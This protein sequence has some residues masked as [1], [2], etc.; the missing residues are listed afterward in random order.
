MDRTINKATVQ[1]FHYDSHDRLRSHL[2]DLVSADN[3]ER[4]LK[5]LKGLTPWQ[6]TCKT[7][8]NEPTRSR[9]DPPYQCRE[10][11]SRL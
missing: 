6:A 4:R 5:T 11:T 8:T 1:R 3:L 2:R 10:Q 7:W 9:L